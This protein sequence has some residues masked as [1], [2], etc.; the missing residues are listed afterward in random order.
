MKRCQRC[1]SRSVTL[2]YCQS[3]STLDPFPRTRWFFYIAI[4]LAC[5]VAAFLA[6]MAAR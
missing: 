3:C 4:G 1:G 6:V 5:A 2:G